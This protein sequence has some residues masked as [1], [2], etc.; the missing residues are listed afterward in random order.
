VQ[1]WRGK[2]EEINGKKVEVV[3]IESFEFQLR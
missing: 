3:S 2:P 1:K